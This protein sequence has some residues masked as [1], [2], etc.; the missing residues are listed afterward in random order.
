MQLILQAIV[1]GSTC[2]RTDSKILVLLSLES[3]NLHR[4]CSCRIHS[5][6]LQLSSTLIFGHFEVNHSNLLL[7]MPCFTGKKN[8]TVWHVLQLADAIHLA[9]SG[10]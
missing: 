1:C 3:G 4:K 9:A 6:K 5:F 10:R 7:Y 2:S 8:L